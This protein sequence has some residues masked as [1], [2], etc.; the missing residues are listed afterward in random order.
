MSRIR[1][2]FQWFL[3]E[4]LPVKADWICIRIQSTFEVS[5]SWISSGFLEK[6]T[7]F[8]FWESPQLFHPTFPSS[9]SPQLS[10]IPNKKVTTFHV[11][12]SSRKVTTFLPE[13]SQLFLFFGKKLGGKAD[14]IFDGKV[15][16][17]QST[18]PV[19]F[20][21]FSW[22]GPKSWPE[23]LTG[24]VDWKMEGKGTPFPVNFSTQL[25]GKKADW[26][27]D[28]KVTTFQSTFPGNPVSFSCFR[29]IFNKKL[30]L[31]VTLKSYK[32]KV[33]LFCFPLSFSSQL[34]WFSEQKSYNFFPKSWP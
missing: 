24:K 28:G 16:T 2:T 22:F 20:P 5:F 29:T 4:K 7:G 15:T 27:F 8:R 10:G 12:F 13:S 17:F 34:F 18:F 6:L 14:W 25:S 9:F 1:I 11:N 31:K 30:P 23:K 26:I 21:V 3:M 32:E 33:H 19:N